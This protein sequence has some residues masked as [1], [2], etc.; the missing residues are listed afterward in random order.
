MSCMKNHIDVLQLIWYKTI[1]FFNGLRLLVD[2]VIM[3]K[4]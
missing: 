3:P 2:S 4:L 1:T